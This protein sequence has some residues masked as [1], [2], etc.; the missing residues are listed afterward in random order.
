VEV[1]IYQGLIFTT[2][3]L[4]RII[5]PKHLEL[6]CSIWTLLTLV[7]LFWPPLIVLQLLVVW[8]TYSVI[9]PKKSAVPSTG[10]EPGGVNKDDRQRSIGDPAADAFATLERLKKEFAAY[11]ATIAEF[12]RREPSESRQFLDSEKSRTLVT[13]QRGVR[14]AEIRAHVTELGI[15]HLVHFTRCENLKSIFRHGL[16]SVSDCAAEG[17]HAI[18]NDKIRLD[19]RPDGTSLSVTFPNYRMFYKYRQLDPSGDWAVL[20]LSSSILWEKECG[21]FKYNAA[22]SRMRRL[23]RASTMTAQALKDM[24]VELDM[25]R[26]HWLSPYDPSDPQAE[27]MVYDCIE[28]T[29]IEAVAF[30]TEEAT[31]SWTHVL[32][33]TDTICAGRGKGL[34]GP[35]AQVRGQ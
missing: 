34:F 35:R 22:D 2:L 16:R 12:P 14:A 28:P 26:E 23:P 25:P 11:N 27:V 10:A 20:I 19:G 1:L 15:P 33:G 18:G 7:N 17:I 31:D 8:G 5:S 21:F 3:V 24:F 6:A 9:R 4:V 29:F 13:Q 30:E 32:G